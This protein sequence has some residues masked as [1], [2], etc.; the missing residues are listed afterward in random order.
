M[1]LWDSLKNGPTRNVTQGLTQLAES[2]QKAI[3]CLKER[4]DHPR[5]IYCEHI[6]SI[7]Q[8][9]PMKEDNRREL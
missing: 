1:Y 9:P 2:Y 4:Y 8:A 3:K 5:L 7:V 6:C